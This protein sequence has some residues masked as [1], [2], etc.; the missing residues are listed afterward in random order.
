MVDS[1]GRVLYPQQAKLEELGK[2]T[3]D[4]LVRDTLY[5]GVGPEAGVDQSS[6]EQFE[7]MHDLIRYHIFS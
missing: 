6:R 4:S 2:H 7:C 1:Q 3:R 5:P